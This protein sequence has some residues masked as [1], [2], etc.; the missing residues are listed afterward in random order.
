[1][2]RAPG[3]AEGELLGGRFQIVRFIAR[4]GMGEVYEAE[5]QVLRERVALK[6]IR[7]DVAGDER[8]MERFLR[9]VHLARSVT[10]PNVSRTFDV[11]HHGALAFLTMELL[12]GETL[13][14]RLAKSGRLTPDEA[15]PLVEQMAAALTAA[16]EAGIVHRD[17]KSANVMLEPDERRPGGVRAVVTDFGLARRDRPGRGSAAPLTETEAVIGTP[18]YMAPEQIEGR[19]ITPATDV[20]A[21]GVVLYEMVTGEQPFEGDTPLSVALKKLKE[22][23]PSPR[24]LAPDLPPVWEKTI[25]RCLERAPADRF[26]SANEVVRVLRGEATATG[27]ATLRRRRKRMAAVAAG[28]LLAAVAAFVASRALGRRPAAGPAAATVRAPRRSIA[29]LGFKNLAGRPEEAW[30]STALSEMLTTELAAGDTL[31]AIPSEDVARVK[32]DLAIPEAD[33]LGKETLARVRKNIGAD[34]VLLGSYLA[35]GPGEGGPIRLDLRLQDTAAGETIALVSEK[36]SATDFD[37][38]ATRAGAQL[39][40]KLSLPAVSEAEAAAVRASLPS[41]PEAARLYAEGLAKL[42]VYDEVAARDLLER[43]VAADP[44][45]ALAHSALAAAWSGL[46]YDAKA[47]AEAKKAF[48]LSGNLSRETRLVVEGRYRAM[49]NEWAKA[50]EIYRSLYTFYPDNLDYGLQLVRAQSRSGRPEDGLATIASLEGAFPDAGA[51]VALAE[52]ETARTVSDFRRTEKAA[53]RA[54]TLAEADGA[55]L[56]AA[57]ARLNQAIARR[58]L[59]DPKGALAIADQSRKL[60]AEA[61]DPSGLASAINGM[62]NCRY[63]LG[64]LPGAREAYA[65]VLRIYREVGNKR[66]EAGALGNL[67]NVMGDQG[68]LVPARRHAEEALALFTEIGD[69]AGV[70]EQL[71]NMGAAMVLAGDFR[72]GRALFERAVP[73]HEKIGDSGGLAIALNNVAE[74]EM[75]ESNLAG[76]GEHFARSLKLFRDSG[77]KSKAVYP[78]VGLATVSI[79][80]GDLAGARTMLEEGLQT[81]RESDDKHESAYALTYL[82]V[83]AAAQDRAPEARKSFEEALKI[84]TDI[85]EPAAAEQSRTD[86]ARLALAEGDFPKAR[87]LARAAA[88]ELGR[89]KI[90]D[91]EAAALA[92]LVRALAA[93]RREDE[94]DRALARAR[95]LAA[96]SQHDG[97]RREVLL[98]SASL[99][100]A[101]GD[102]AGAARSLA[103]AAARAQMQGL[104]AW[105]LEARLAEGEILAAGG[106]K[107]AAAAKLAQ[108]Q[109]DAGAKG[110]QRIARQ[111]AEAR[112]R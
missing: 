93:E 71:N 101:R 29:V 8:A 40:E 67:A 52:A 42:R 53:V 61:R 5:D 45:H 74:M 13:A 64:D 107:D 78:L 10:H 57:T 4:G 54:A 75:H 89:Q 43:A 6:T 72:G 86:L 46:G 2:W 110:F 33:T 77:Q 38:L 65:E 84:R 88:D 81:C 16:H 41:S 92:I 22:A 11:F 82:G 49:S 37:G 105:A 79:E 23:A 24:K 63:D 85:G 27:P 112:G 83:V 70:A 28:L 51:R 100:A 60:F 3:L 25:L 80:M 111:A 19:A 36:G 68:E 106:A 58:N 30:V 31:R 96:A 44:G 104:I 98:A 69:E 47:I 59:G 34:L 14:E 26:A 18:D 91:D 12:S 102:S 62:G 9:E 20:Y 32:T 95:P 99:R 103:D 90:A 66:G 55:R 76:A 35:T 108:V 94:A 48:E 17:F 50:V 97:V 56:L 87:E 109:R 15:L 7:P 21:L 39:R 73:I 1:M